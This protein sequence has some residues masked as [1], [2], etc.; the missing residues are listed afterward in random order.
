MLGRIQ[1]IVPIVLACAT[2][3]VVLSSFFLNIPHGLAIRQAAV[4]WATVL[5]AFAVLLGLVNVLVVHVQRV[6]NQTR[7]WPYSLILLLSAVGVIVA[8]LVDTIVARRPGASGPIVGFIFRFGLVSGE[9]ALAGSLLFFLT[10]AA[11]RAI[12]RQLT[13][14]LF[15]FMGSALIVLAA[16]VP[17]PTPYSTI[18]AEVRDR[19]VLPWAVGGARGLILGVA[20]GTVAMGVR[21]LLGLEQPYLSSAES[22]RSVTAP[23]LGGQEPVGWMERIDARLGIRDEQ[24]VPAGAPGPEKTQT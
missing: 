1:R 19:A 5:A 23:A 24:P 6:G 4:E 13:P 3:I 7:G 12:R 17:F 10:L 2:G 18:L 15:L 9:A 22:K 16:A 21:L 14:G 20:L 8:G 11:Y